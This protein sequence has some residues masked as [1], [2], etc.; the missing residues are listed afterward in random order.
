MWINSILTEISQ[1]KQDKKDLRNFGIVF[2]IV[3]CII[4]VI[5]FVKQGYNSVWVYI[6]PGLGLIFLL[7]GIF[8]PHSLKG[9]HKIWMA[10][11]TSL[12]YLFTMVILTLAYFLVITPAG[13]LQK[14]IGN[15]ILD[16]K[17]DKTER[18][19]WKDHE[20]VTNIESY[21]KMF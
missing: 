17:M 4:G 12:G 11:A 20:K 10:L 18:T 8:S 7:L 9:I 21:K 2:F 19:Y 1:I 3:G 14:A 5:L 13:L 16:L 15:D 6:G